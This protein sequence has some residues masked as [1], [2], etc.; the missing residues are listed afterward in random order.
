MIFL[1]KKRLYASLFLNIKISLLGRWSISQ[2]KFYISTTLKLHN[3]AIP[4][5]QLRFII[6][7][8]WTGKYQDFYWVEF[9]T[10]DFDLITMVKTIPHLIIGKYIGIV[11][12]DSGGFIPTKE[13]LQR[14]WRT[15]KRVS[16]SPIMNKSELDGPIFE[17]NDQWCLFKKQTD[18]DEMTD[19]VNYGGFR[20]L[21]RT[22]ELD[23]IDSTWDKTA[24]KVEIEYIK[25]LQAKF[26]NEVENINPHNIIINGDFFIFCT[27]DEKEIKTIIHGY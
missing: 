22:S 10:S 23:I 12:F 15:N 1:E 18:F 20:L 27:K 25:S 17:N 6:M 8:Y 2:W 14:G 19:F 7:N 4:N 3:H 21:D 26:W 11:C 16:F 24:L 5:I 9:A 13:E